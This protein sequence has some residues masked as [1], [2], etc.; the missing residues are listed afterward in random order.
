MSTKPVARTWGATWP[1]KQPPAMTRGADGLRQPRQSQAS[2]QAHRFFAEPDIGLEPLDLTL[3]RSPAHLE[4]GRI[5]DGDAQIREG[6]AQCGGQRGEGQWRPEAHA[7]TDER[8]ERPRRAHEKEELLHG[9]GP[10]FPGCSRLHAA[11]VS[12]MRLP[13]PGARARSSPQ[14]PARSGRPPARPR[15]LIPASS[16]PI[17]PAA[18]SKP[19][20]RFAKPSARLSEAA[21]PQPARAREINQAEGKE[22]SR[23]GRAL[24]APWSTQWKPSR[25]FAAGRDHRTE[26]RR[27]PGWMRKTRPSANATTAASRAPC[28]AGKMR[29]LAPGAQVRPPPVRRRGKASGSIGGIGDIQPRGTTAASRIRILDTGRRARLRSSSTNARSRSRVASSSSDKPAETAI[30]WPSG[31]ARSDTTSGRSRRCW[32][33]GRAAS[34]GT[35]LPSRGISQT[36]T[37]RSRAW[38]RSLETGGPEGLIAHGWP[39]RSAPA[40]SGLKPAA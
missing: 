26:D 7:G 19:E 3:E 40:L 31:E 8:P 25:T 17:T 20:T 33:F 1:K 9:G 36:D 32:R 2:T 27:G 28:S 39:G 12:R 6:L 29:A 35:G 11:T 4:N 38:V 23:Q 15:R 34:R 24:T 21:L 22:P 13:E 37:W 16:T 30:V 10:G 18:K 14:T 5:E